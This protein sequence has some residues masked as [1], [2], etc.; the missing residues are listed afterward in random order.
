MNKLSM[1]EPEPCLLY[2]EWMLR[3][4]VESGDGRR[5]LI[6]SLVPFSVPQVVAAPHIFFLL[7]KPSI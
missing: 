7:P 2:W 4:L 1:S 3:G 6:I 5:G